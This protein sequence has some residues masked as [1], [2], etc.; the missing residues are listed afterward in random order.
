VPIPGE[1]GPLGTL[2]VFSSSAARPF[3]ADLAAEVEALAQRAGR[4]IE[5]ALRFRAARHQADVDSLTGVHT[6]GY[7]DETITR[8]VARA[9]R[10]ERPLALVFFDIDDFKAINTAH[11]WL[12][13]DAV[14]REAAARVR[15]V[16]RHSDI[17][18][19]WGG[20][21]FALILPESTLGDATQLF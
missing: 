13:G 4:A 16:V 9:H 17:A 20:D 11:G 14:L 3:D 12:G 6:R 19:R 7:F 1:E 10:Y 2:T 21:E 8:E 15:D 18:C 5:N